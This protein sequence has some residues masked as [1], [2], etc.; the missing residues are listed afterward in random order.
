[1]GN[2]V[3]PREIET[4]M[5]LSKIPYVKIGDGPKKVV[6]FPSTNEIVRNPVIKPEFARDLYSRYF[7]EDFTIYLLGY[8]PNLPP[9]YPPANIAEDFAEI[10]KTS[11]GPSIIVAISY[12]G[13][14]AIPFAV[15]HHK[16]VN[17][18]ILISSAYS[19]S[20][21]GFKLTAKWMDLAKKGKAMD[22]MISL[23]D[24]YESKTDRQY[25]QSY[26]RG[27]WNNQQENLNPLSTFINAYSHDFNAIA[28]ANRQMLPRIRAPTLIIG[29]SKDKLIST[30]LFM[31]SANLIPEKIVKIFNLEGHLIFLE[32]H[33]VIHTEIDHFLSGTTE[34]TEKKETA[35]N[36]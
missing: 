25:F 7:S 14:V 34:E 28:E 21:E 3:K 29:G 11:I 35:E 2:K 27:H 13:F 31:E 26:T 4:G 36:K 1:M 5:F 30:E 15:R 8:D 19:L 12:G 16:L 22:L 9:N 24:L 17:S 32:R 10:I 20:P 18:L 23:L 6:I 33:S